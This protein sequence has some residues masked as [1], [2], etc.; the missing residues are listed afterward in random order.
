MKSVQI[1]S[2]FWSVFSHIRTEYGDLLRKSP[3][4][5]RIRDN[6]DQ[7]KLRIWILFTQWIVLEISVTEFY[8]CMSTKN[9]SYLLKTRIKG[10]E[11]RAQLDLVLRKQRLG[12]CERLL[13]Y[14]DTDGICFDERS[15]GIFYVK[16]VNNICN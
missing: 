6:A 15:K 1:Q 2:F 3:Y 9:D 14:S 13:K 7:I 5:V 12:R 10:H 16:L 4:S 11:I 8:V